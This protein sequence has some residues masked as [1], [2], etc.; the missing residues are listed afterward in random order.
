MTTNRTG[1]Q[2]VCFYGEEKLTR[3]QAGS[4]TE[5]IDGGW[6]KVRR[7]IHRVT[8]RG[9]VSGNTYSKGFFDLQFLID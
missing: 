9:L 8:L 5:F 7:Y 1:E 3:Q 4:E 6:G 2:P